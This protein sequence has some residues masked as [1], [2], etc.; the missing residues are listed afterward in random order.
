MSVPVKGG[1]GKVAWQ[2]WVEAEDILL[3]FPVHSPSVSRDEAE[4]PDD[5]LIDYV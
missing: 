4:N 3:N 2:L 5:S 1:V